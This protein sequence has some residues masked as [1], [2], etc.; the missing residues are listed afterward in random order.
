LQLLT[1]PP[2]LFCDEPTTGLDSYNALSVIKTL[3]QLATRSPAT[4]D[5]N[6]DDKKLD[7]NTIDEHQLMNG[8]QYLPLIEKKTNSSYTLNGSSYITVSDLP[9]VILCSIHQPASD[10]FHCFTHIILMQG[11][12]IMYQGSTEEASSFF[13]RLGYHC[14][15]AYNPAEFYSNMASIDSAQPKESLL[16]VRTIFERYEDERVEHR[17]QYTLKSNCLLFEEW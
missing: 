7:L 3:K 10:V 16:R 1:E 11:G 8:N 9:K 12:R 4:N 17:C 6:L 15:S 5:D 13:S 14:P 2:V